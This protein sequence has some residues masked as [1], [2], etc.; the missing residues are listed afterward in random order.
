M[1]GLPGVG[2]S[3]VAKLLAKKEKAIILR[4]DKI[5]RKHIKEFGQSLDSNEPYPDSA[6]QKVYEIMFRR[7]EKFLKEGKSV[8]LDATFAQRKNRD[9]AREL[10]RSLGIPSR[11][12]YVVC[13]TGDERQNDAIIQKRTFQRGRENKSAARFQI[14]LWYALYYFEYPS[15]EEIDLLINNAAELPQLA[16]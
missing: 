16:N 11:L 9:R 10:A 2:K 1:C 4:T 8:I 5:R 6:M 13:D 14:Y 15:E 3:T 12:V 7:A